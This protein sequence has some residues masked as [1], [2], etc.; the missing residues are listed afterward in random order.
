MKIGFDGKRVFHNTTGLGNYSRD[1]I[2]IMVKYFPKDEYFIYNP[3]QIPTV[4]S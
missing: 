4:I 2:R 1:L 3:N